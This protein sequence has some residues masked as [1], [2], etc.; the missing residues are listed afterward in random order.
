MNLTNHQSQLPFIIFPENNFK[1]L[2]DT[3]S[4]KSFVIPEIAQKYYKNFIK[5]DPFQISTAHGTSVE[6]HSVTLPTS[7]IFNLKNQNFKFH[8][9]KFHDNFHFLLGL[10]NLKLLNAQIDLINDVLITKN[11]KI[12]IQ[13]TDKPEI[14]KNCFETNVNIIARSETII[15]IAIN[16]VKNGEIIIPYTKLNQLEIPETLTVVKDNRAICSIINPTEKNLSLKLKP[17]NVEKFENYEYN[18][19][20]PN[21]NTINFNNYNFKFDTSKIRSNHMN[22]EEK[23]EILKLIKEY[24]DIFHN[25]NQPLSFTS[26]IKHHIHTTDEV[27]VF[28]KSYRYPEIHRAE[29]KKQIQE[30]LSQNIIQPSH[31]PWSSPIWV[32]PKKLD[33]VGKRKWRIVIDYRKLNDKTIGDRYPLPNITDLLDKLGRCQYFSTL[34]LASGFHQIPLAKKDI[35]K[36]AFNTENG[37]FE[38]LRMPFGLKNAPATFQRIMENILRG[39]QNEKCLIYLDDIIIFSTSLQEHISRLRE[40]FNRLRK[41]NFKVQLNKSEFLRKEVA[42]LGHIVTPDGVKPNPDKIQAIKNFPLPKTEKQIKGFLGLLGYYRK[43]IKDFAKLTKPLTKCLK[44]ENKINIDDPEYLSCFNMCKNLLINEPILQYPDFSQPFVITTD[45]SNYA[46]GAILSQG[47][48]GNDLPISYASRTLNS[49]ETKYSTTEKELL[50][51]VWAVKYFRP[52]IFGRKFKIVTDHKPLQWLFS[53][54]EHT[55]SKL[56]RWRLRLEEYD[57]EIIYKKG[58]SNKNADALSRIE[59]NVNKIQKQESNIDNQSLAVEINDLGNPNNLIENEDSQTIHTSNE[60]P[61]TS[62][63]IAE[64]PVNHGKNQIIIS[65]VNFN[66]LPVSVIKLFKNKQR[67]LVQISKNNFEKDIINFV[68]KFIVPKVK[69]YVY[70]EDPVYESFAVIIQNY[71]KNSQINF[72]K[73]TQKLIDISNDDEIKNIIQ[74]YH[75]GKTN[76]RGIDETE[77]RLKNIYYWPNQ[78]KSIQSYINLCDICQVTKYDRKPL[79]PLFNI[80]PTATRPFEIIHIDSISLEKVKFLSIVDSFS[81]YAQMYKLNS[82]QG[83]EIVNNLIKYFT[84]HNIPN[85]IVSDNGTEFENSLLKE[86]LQL[87]KIEIHFISTQHP[88]SNGIVER[89]HSTIIEHIRLLNNQN[90]YQNESIENKINYALLAYNNS[91]HSTTNLKPCEIVTG[92]FENESPFNIDIE[93]QLVNNYIETHKNK[94]KLLYHKINKDIQNKK[95]KVINKIN[96]N[97]EDIAEIPENIYVKNNQKQSKTKNKY[98][99]EQI[100]KINKTLKTASIVAKHHNTKGKIHISNIRRPRKQ[101]Y[102]FKTISGSL[103]SDKVQK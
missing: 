80:T 24:S 98:K 83:I 68:K 95:E 62:I 5:N 44:K 96:E 99:A 1:V 69:Y 73:C 54:K 15:E 82:S 79:N 22:S 101:T 35:P 20:K 64:C 76:H 84:H 16:N 88:E 13:Y 56:A 53:I 18:I 31:S 94:C 4:T 66:P 89:F 92:H 21:I 14:N 12:K 65:Q 55:N 33:S 52:Y 28:T 25:E 43:F 81:K 42:Y 23:N 3:G 38:F 60:H 17:I 102:K 61:V 19:D 50:A 49:S 11:S 51:V 26:E 103:Q 91:I 85:Q 32:V 40:V 57:Y 48:I 100:T 2:I 97:R 72:I 45:A 47:K 70:F 36:T 78:R 90:E 93:K 39:I 87:H 71:F 41:A 86:L 27:P 58:I 46:I 6:T 7:K 10:D 59:L 8:L 34:D 30:M 9:F 37:H 74:N 67:Y 63:P 29:V 75:E 77:K